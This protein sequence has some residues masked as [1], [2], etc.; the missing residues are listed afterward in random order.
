MPL[1]TADDDVKL[2]KVGAVLHRNNGTAELVD[3]DERAS[4]NEAWLRM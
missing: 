1:P 4:V 3:D 2:G